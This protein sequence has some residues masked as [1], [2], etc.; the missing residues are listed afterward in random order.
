M[1]SFRLGAGKR[2]LYRYCNFTE[3]LVETVPISL[4]H[5]CGSELHILSFEELACYYSHNAILCALCR[6]RDRTISSSTLSD[7]AWRVVSEGKDCS[8]SLLIVRRSQIITAL[9]SEYCS[10]LGYSSILAIFGTGA[11]MLIRSTVIIIFSS[12]HSLY[13]LF[14]QA[15]HPTRNFATLGQFLVLAACR[16]AER[17]I[18]YHSRDPG[19]WPLRILQHICYFV[20]TLPTTYH[21]LSDFEDF[22]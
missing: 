10:I 15:I 22:L 12:V 11:H 20:L 8:F 17:T 6:H 16:H 5:S 4:R 14:G 18:S 9:S 3:S 19:V 21:L 2:H 13:R 1:G 7:G